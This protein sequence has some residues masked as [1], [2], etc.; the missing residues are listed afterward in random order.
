MPVGQDRVARS[1]VR[2]A[3]TVELE[4]MVFSWNN[5]VGQGGALSIELQGPIF[6]SGGSLSGNVA[7]SPATCSPRSGVSVMPGPVDGRSDFAASSAGNTLE[8]IIAEVYA[9]ALNGAGVTAKNDPE[10]EQQEPV[11]G[12]RGQELAHLRS[13]LCFHLSSDPVSWRNT[14]SRFS[15]SVSRPNSAMSGD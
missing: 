2:A 9:G 6:Y 14:S 10:N 7:A 11:D 13:Q 8:A 12:A 1:P 3:S 4:Q 15:S 5:T